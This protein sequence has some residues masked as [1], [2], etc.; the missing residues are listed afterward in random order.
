MYYND[1]IEGTNGRIP[2]FKT[3]NGSKSDIDALLAMRMNI[4]NY[5]HIIDIFAPCIVKSSTWNKDA[6]M[7]QYCG[8]NADNFHKYILSISD[9]AFLLLVLI[10]TEKRQNKSTDI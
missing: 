6:I 10:N 9:E 2:N 5:V 4:V 1:V 7:K 3:N 8:D